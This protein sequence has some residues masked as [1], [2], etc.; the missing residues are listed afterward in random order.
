MAPL[1]A[2][3]RAERNRL[4]AT[5]RGWTQH[6]DG[7]NYWLKPGAKDWSPLANFHAP[8]WTARLLEELTAGRSATIDRDSEVEPSRGIRIYRYALGSFHGF[9]T[10]WFDTLAD[11]A[12]QAWLVAQEEKCDD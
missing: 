11:A 10:S 3:D 6:E 5:L 1:T 8:E 9:T 7:G 12:A 4:I 2:Q